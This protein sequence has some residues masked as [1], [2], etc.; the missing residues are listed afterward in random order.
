M[1][2]AEEYIEQ[3]PMW[4]RKK[5]TLQDV[6]AFLEEL[7][8]P[9]RCFKIIHVAGTNG[10]GSVC[11]YLTSVLI[12]AGYR[13]GTFISPHLEQIR[14]RFLICGQL[15]DHESFQK[16]FDQVY[17][18]T[19]R[20]TERGFS[21]PS[22]FEFLFYIAMVLFRDK[23]VETAVVETGMG[24][25][26]DATNAVEKPLITV[27]TSI[28]LDHTQYLGD[29]IAQIAA[30]KAGI[31]KKDVP[32]VFEDSQP[33]ASP[34][35]SGA[36]Y[37]LG[38][39]RYPVNSGDYQIIEGYS[40]GIEGFYMK[41]RLLDRE[42]IRV[43]VPFAARY[44]AAN[45]MLAV[46]TLEVLKDRG[47]PVSLS[48]LQAGIAAT[49]WPGRMEQAV[50]GVYLDGAHNPGG[51]RALK[52]AVLDIAGSRKVPL[53]LL[54]AVSADKDC[55]HMAK[56][57]CEDIN[58]TAITVVH[59]RNDRSMD[60]ASLAE[61]F[62]IYASCPVWEYENAAQAL[63]HM[64]DIKE[65]GILFCAGSLYLIGE[66]KEALALERSGKS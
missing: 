61:A 19:M 49:R 16:S 25:R 23:Q 52:E 30:E 10:K 12:G 14:E 56:D 24:G 17:E 20:M 64:M 26:L 58:W 53:Y 5:N 1:I 3:I 59:L 47:L 43:F 15:T 4:T 18:A 11:A 45:A 22:Y 48:Q 39:A 9:D 36:A 63:E 37:R 51:V 8:N 40:P 35:I 2:N 57:L 13:T 66:I 62:R 21:H 28:S 65:D 44:Q 32:V 6:R 33:Q 31:I 41:A 7:G 38:A 29:T 46:R 54:F 60:T 50:P 42:W 55:R 34:V 27:I